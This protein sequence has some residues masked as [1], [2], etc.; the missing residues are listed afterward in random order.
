MTQ[1]FVITKAKKL[2]RCGL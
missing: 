2:G 1:T